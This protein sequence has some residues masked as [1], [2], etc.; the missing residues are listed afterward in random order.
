MAL[1][2]FNPITYANRLKEAGMDVKVADVQAEEM[3]NIFQSSAATKQDVE[4]VKHD[5]QLVK[6]DIE[7]VR[8]EMNVMESNLKGFIVK[9][10]ITLGTVIV[11]LPQ[12]EIIIKHFFA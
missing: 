7:M 11:L 5:I 2:A 10:L 1:P 4:M 12:L 8:K 3:V 6:V 9:S